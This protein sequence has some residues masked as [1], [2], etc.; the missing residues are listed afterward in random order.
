FDVEGLFAVPALR[1]LL[2]PFLRVPV[3][4]RRDDLGDVRRVDPPV[5]RP[6]VKV[7]LDCWRGEG[8]DNR[9]G[10]AGAIVTGDPVRAG[11]LRW[12]VTARDIGK[13]AGAVRIGEAGRG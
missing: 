8:V 5:S 11:N 9:D 1:I 10:L 4:P 2:L 13:G 3:R 7:L 12:G 6:L